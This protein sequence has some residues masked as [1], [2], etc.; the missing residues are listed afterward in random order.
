MGAAQSQNQPVATTL[1][2]AP[3]TST[4]PL[5]RK[6]PRIE[7]TLL[8][9]P[10]PPDD[11]DSYS[12]AYAASYFSH[13]VGK[14]SLV[15]RFLHN[16]WPFRG[17]TSRTH[18]YHHTCTINDMSV[19]CTIIDVDG[20]CRPARDNT[21]KKRD[22]SLYDAAG[23]MFVYDIT[24]ASSWKFTK[25]L[26]K[27]TL[28]WRRRRRDDIALYMLLGNKADLEDRRRVQYLEAREFAERNGMSLLEVSAKEGTNVEFAFMSF[29]AQ[30]METVD[31]DS[32]STLPHDSV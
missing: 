12:L 21:Q 26:I 24:N 17:E 31:N 19:N 2:H 16:K 20:Y 22:L 15:G 30:L 3:P 5:P 13:S 7:L 25:E 9:S 4:P 6:P 10:P 28:D 32:T 29:I 18:P 11:E 8:P 1:S 27:E 14:T 23:I